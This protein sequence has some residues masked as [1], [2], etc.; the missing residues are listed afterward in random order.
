VVN[1]PLTTVLTVSFTPTT[2]ELFQLIT[3]SGHLTYL[4]NSTGIGDKPI[5]ILIEFL[6]GGSLIGSYTTNATTNAGSGYYQTTHLVKIASERIRITAMY[7][8]L[9]V[10]IEG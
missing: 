2:V 7:L 8:S 9:N 5:T 4:T 6:T 1:D 3:I 10:T